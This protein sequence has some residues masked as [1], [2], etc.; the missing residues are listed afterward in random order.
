MTLIYAV[1]F[2]SILERVVPKP[3]YSIHFD[4][5]IAYTESYSLE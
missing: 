5:K 1:I 3:F 4:P 2:I